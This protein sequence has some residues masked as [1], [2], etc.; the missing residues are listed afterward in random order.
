MFVNDLV[1]LFLLVM[2]GYCVCFR[3]LFFRRF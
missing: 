2:F 1:C 3:F